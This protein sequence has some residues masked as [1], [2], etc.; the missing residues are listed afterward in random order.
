MSQEGLAEGK[1]P[2]QH[3]QKD[4]GRPDQAESEED[5]RGLL[6]KAKDKLTGR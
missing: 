2:A 6:D 1:E 4:V 5:D 3:L